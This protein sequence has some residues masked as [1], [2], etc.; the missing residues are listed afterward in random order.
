[1]LD[2]NGQVTDRALRLG[3]LARA[4]QMHRFELW[5]AR[6]EP[7]VGVLYDWE[8]EAVWAVMSIVGR[9]SFRLKPVEARI[10]VS[11]AL[12][13]ANI[14]FEYV[15]PDDLHHGLAPRYP[16]IYLPAMLALQTEVLDKLADYV[17]QGGRVVMDLPSAWY[18]EFT[19]RFPTGKETK[20]AEAFGVSLDDFQYSGVNRTLRLG[21]EK[22]DGFVATL[23]PI[24]ARVLARYDNGLPA[25]VEN[26]LDRGTS[27]LLAFEASLAC[28]R[29]GHQAAEKRLVDY[30]LTDSKP[31][32][33][34]D[35]AIVYRLAT[36]ESDHYFLV[37]DGPA[38]KVRLTLASSRKAQ[39]VTDA[40][41]GE[42]LDPNQP[43][44]LD[45]HD[46]RWLRYQVENTVE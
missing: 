42:I 38:R 16:I 41:T 28:H 4:M 17:R 35:E 32:Y 19:Q 39:R 12:I 43:I 18:D 46:A 2:R 25:V 26:R 24:T 21:G 7:L 37:N 44:E 31:P 3:E 27:V 40:V 5:Q 6:K 9:E 20:F 29:P 14:P 30:A 23:T 8:N 34:C 1:L 33:R 10:G 36:P 45:A 13:N 15:T 22:L 11:R